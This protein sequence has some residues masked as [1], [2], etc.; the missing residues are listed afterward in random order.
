[1]TSTSNTRKVTEPAESG[2]YERQRI[3]ADKQLSGTY[4]LGAYAGEHVAGTEFV[5]GASLVALG[6]STSDL[7]WGLLLGNLLA[8]L[9]WAWVCSPIATRS[10]MTIY[11][12]LERLAGK[13]F[14]TAYNLLNGL[15][16]AVVSGAMVTVSASAFRVMTDIPPQTAWYPQSVSFVML[17]LFVGA[18]TVW[19][20]IK[21]FKLIANFSTVCSPWMATMFLASGIVTVPV[22]LH[23]GQLDGI[24]SLNGVLDTFVWT[25]TTP[26]G[27]AGISVWVIAAWAWGANL[28]MHLGMSDMSILRFARKSSY[29][30]F[31]AAGMYIGH[32]M[33]WICAGLM[34]ATAALLAKSSLI[35]MDPGGVAFRILGAMGLIAVVV[36]GWTTSI[37][38]LYRAGLAFQAVFDRFSRVQVTVATGAATTVIACFPFVF[39]QWL[40]VLSY[41]IMLI[42]PVGAIIAAEH[43][44]LPRLGIRP[45]WR[46]QHGLAT[47]LPAFASWG[48]GV[49]VGIMLLSLHAIHLFALFI[50]VWL[51]S[52]LG[53]PLLCHLAGAA[54]GNDAREPYEAAYGPVLKHDSKE[55][56]PTGYQP[57]NRR[58]PWY[59]IA[60]VCLIAILGIAGWGAITDS[61]VEHLDIF[62][63]LII[64]PTLLYF[65]AATV[66]MKSRRKPRSRTGRAT[67]SLVS[68]A[69]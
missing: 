29:G 2:E 45:F 6:V 52:F 65:I 68:R 5:I 23:T 35:E 33:A 61:P 50:P 54:E 36:A 32:F 53:Y 43:F 64:I 40:N 39:T 8:V 57:V 37:P 51:V 4:F 31:S 7:I 20:T 30:Y 38:S 67:S 63:H 47:N 56:P 12:Y 22:L 10:R 26:D 49:V 66:W 60:V 24:T 58:N 15:I 48:L 13:H 59:A 21:G 14:S 9:S 1:M 55:A 42:A 11:W 18:I 41:F 16:F 44:L 27:S 17:A 28:P 19:L 69:D 46:E 62:Q 34:G 25:G 3:P